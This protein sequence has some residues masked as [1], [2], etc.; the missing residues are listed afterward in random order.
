MQ[1]GHTYIQNYTSRAAQAR[2]Y[3]QWNLYITATQG[4]GQN[5]PLYT[6]DRYIQVIVFIPKRY[7]NSAINIKLLKIHYF[8]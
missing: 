7:L 8:K 6:G 5:W 3:V 2:L 1:I 4:T